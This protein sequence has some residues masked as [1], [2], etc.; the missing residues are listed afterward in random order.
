MGEAL[1]T[2]GVKIKYVQVCFDSFEERYTFSDIRLKYNNL[3][4]FEKFSVKVEQ[5]DRTQSID[6]CECSTDI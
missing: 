3:Q 5:S 4:V 6:F 1:R 2:Q